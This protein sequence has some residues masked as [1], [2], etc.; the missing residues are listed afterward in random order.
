MSC[1]IQ[2]SFGVAALPCSIR[3]ALVKKGSKY[4]IEMQT[5]PIKMKRQTNNPHGTVS[6]EFKL[7]PGHHAAIAA[8]HSDEVGNGMLRINYRDV[9]KYPNYLAVYEARRVEFH[10]K[11][12]CCQQL[13]HIKPLIRTLQSDG[14]FMCRF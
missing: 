13:S 6:A 5:M 8:S 9:K 7:T 11:C 2:R 10:F 12:L 14:A 4:K 3:C 1:Q